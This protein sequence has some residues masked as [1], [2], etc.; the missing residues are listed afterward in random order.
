MC[1]LSVILDGLVSRGGHSPGTGLCMTH[2]SREHSC[3]AET[4]SARE[5][6]QATVILSPGLVPHGAEA[7]LHPCSLWVGTFVGSYGPPWVAT[8]G[9]LPF[10]AVGL[11]HGAE[12]KGST[13]CSLIPVPGPFGEANPAHT[14]TSHIT[15]HVGKKALDESG[16]LSSLKQLA[17]LRGNEIC[18]LERGDAKGRAVWRGARPDLSYHTDVVTGAGERSRYLLRHKVFC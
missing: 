8:F 6:Q 10:K 4:P 2:P 12:E 18:S 13:S 16:S 7:H 5:R 11:V 14:D 1:V 9:Q 15:R 17:L 3:R